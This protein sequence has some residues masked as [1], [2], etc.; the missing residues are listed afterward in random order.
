MYSFDELKYIKNRKSLIGMKAE[1]LICLRENGFNVPDGFVVTT[2]ELSSITLE[3]LATYADE[4]TEYAVRSSGVN[5]D[6]ANSSFAGQ[7]DTFL[8]VKGYTNLRDAIN[9]CAQSIRNER[10][11]AY[12]RHNNIDLSGN[13]MAVI[14]QRMVNSEKSGVA[15][16]IDSVNGFDK[17]ILIEAV[18]GLGDKLVSGHV[19]P[20]TYSYNWV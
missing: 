2:D 11:T 19:T 4:H 16:S 18:S 13:K 10:V 20:S 3:K 1:S 15:F 14:V 6:L 17:V 9:K 8:N 7:Y 12:A 5:E